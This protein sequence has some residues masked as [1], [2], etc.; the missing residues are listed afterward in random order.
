MSR[1]KTIFDELRSYLKKKNG[2]EQACGPV[3]INGTEGTNF[4]ME[5]GSMVHIS[6]DYTP[7]EEEIENHDEI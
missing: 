5:D 7:D 1:K 2:R 4:L 3:Y 6:V